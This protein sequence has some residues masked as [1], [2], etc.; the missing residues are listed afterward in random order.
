LSNISVLTNLNFINS[1]T[2]N[3]NNTDFPADPEVGM[4]VMVE[5]ILYIYSSIGGVTT[6]YPLNNKYSSYVHTQGVPSVSW[7][8]NHNFES[9]D[10]IY[11]VYDSNN[12]VVIADIDFVSNNTITV[13]LTEAI[14]GRIVVFAHTNQFAPKAFKTKLYQF[15]CV[16]EGQT[17]IQLPTEN[18]YTPGNNEIEVEVEGVPRFLFKNEFIETDSTTITLATPLVVNE[19]VTIRIYN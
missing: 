6:W 3:Y 12:D 9:Y 4:Q 16:T 14:T 8:V 18:T 19:I 15:E 17:V 2:T 1:Y 7:T 10:L 11:V 13:N 5:G